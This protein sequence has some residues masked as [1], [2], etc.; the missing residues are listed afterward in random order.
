MFSLAMTHAPPAG[1]EPAACGLGIRRSIHLS[2]GS[3][4]LH[5]EALKC[6]VFAILTIPQA[7]VNLL[8]ETHHSYYVWISQSLMFLSSTL[9]V[10]P[11]A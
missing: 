6:I 7:V 8:V 3:T 10:L 11:A 2:Y 9:P 5:A 4:S 1:F